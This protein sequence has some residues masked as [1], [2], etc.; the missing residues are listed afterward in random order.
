MGDVFSFR[1]LT[2]DIS[3]C[4]SNT[5]LKNG[6]FIRLSAIQYLFNAKGGIKKTS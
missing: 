6:L 5:F 2:L 3:D 1:I 4:I